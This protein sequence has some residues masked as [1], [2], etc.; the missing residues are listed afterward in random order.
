MQLGKVSAEN[1]FF[2]T[3]GMLL[4]INGKLFQDYYDSELKYLEEN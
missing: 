3:G 4:G 2:I 1:T